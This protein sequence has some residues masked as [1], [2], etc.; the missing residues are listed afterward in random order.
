MGLARMGHGLRAASASAAAIAWMAGL[1]CDAAPTSHV[2]VAM[3]YEP[4]RDC[5]DPSTSVAFIDTPDGSLECA[6][7]CLVLSAP[8]ATPTEKV[9]VST[10]CPPYPDTLDSTEADP[11]CPAALAAYVRG[12]DTCEPGG[13]SSDPA[14]SGAQDDGSADGAPE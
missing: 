14:D 10:M 2:Y 11:T 1:G 5:L 3:L 7:T 8:P 6:P 9:Y 4:A 13:G 12:P